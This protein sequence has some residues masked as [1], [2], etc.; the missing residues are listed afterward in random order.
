MKYEILMERHMKLAE[1]LKE[2]EHKHRMSIFLNL[3]NSDE[4]KKHIEYLENELFDT[5]V[6]LI[7]HV[8]EQLPTL[9]ENNNGSDSEQ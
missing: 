5:R 7:E 1:D 4:L 9:I 2:L 3:G 6:Q 8:K